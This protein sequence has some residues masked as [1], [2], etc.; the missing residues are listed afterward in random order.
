MKFCGLGPLLIFGRSA[1]AKTFGPF[2]VAA[3]QGRPLGDAGL[4]GA[5]GRRQPAEHRR[6]GPVE[7]R[8]R[9]GLPGAARELDGREEGLKAMWGHL[10]L[11]PKVGS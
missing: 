11:L 3:H 10:R 1:V 4:G 7:R 5:E 8:P 2:E 9:G 6:Q